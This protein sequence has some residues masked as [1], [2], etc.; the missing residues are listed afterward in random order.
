MLDRSSKGRQPHGE[1][2]GKSLLTDASVLAIRSRR[3][4]GERSAQLA[5]EYGV[6]V[7]TI[8]KVI[9]G[10]RWRHV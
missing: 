9:S 6:S 4:A 2:N 10:T 1:R 5:A 3:A 8:H 7:S